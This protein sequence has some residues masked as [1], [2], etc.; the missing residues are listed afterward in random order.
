MSASK[1]PI[2]TW[3][4]QQLEIDTDNTDRISILQMEQPAHE[5]K[6]EMLEGSSA[7]EKAVKMVMKLKEVK[8]I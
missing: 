3:D 8:V 5:S 4:A 1:I 2:S 6:C 7:E